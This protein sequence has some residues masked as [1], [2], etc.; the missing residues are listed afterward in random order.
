L[1]RHGLKLKRRMRWRFQNGPAA[2]PISSQRPTTIAYVGQSFLSCS[3]VLLHQ[4]SR[5]LSSFPILIRPHFTGFSPAFCS[6]K[7]RRN[8]RNMSTSELS[9]R[10]G[11]RIDGPP[12]EASPPPSTIHPRS[13]P[14]PRTVLRS[15]ASGVVSDIRSRA[16]FYLSD[17]SDA[18]NYRVIPATALIFFAK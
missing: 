3:L 13:P 14:K 8:L 10:P 1:G 6:G 11:S 9:H 2:F 18:W 17:W 12:L 5:L 7:A 4:P 16:P 15:L